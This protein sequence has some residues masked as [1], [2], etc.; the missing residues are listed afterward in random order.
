MSNYINYSNLNVLIF[1]LNIFFFQK[2]YLDKGERELS[3]DFVIAP[4]PMPHLL[5][6]LALGAA[7][8]SP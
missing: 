8:L 4:T 1:N 5:P 2:G 3:P 6:S 7:I